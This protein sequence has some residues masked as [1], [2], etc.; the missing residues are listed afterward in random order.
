MSDIDG[1]VQ[2]FLAQK[3]VAVV[4]VSDRRETGCNAAYRRFK[5]AGYKTSAVNPRMAE[6]EG[7]PCYPDLASIPEAP[8]AVFILTN[9]KVS[10][11]ILRQC[12][13]LG[14]ENVWMHC[15]MGTKPGLASGT[16]SVSQ[17]AVQLARENG[18]NVIPGSCPNQFL[19]PDFGHSLMRMLWRT[20]GFM[21]TSENGSAKA[22][23]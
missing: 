14:I 10:E 18:I 16:T 13:D 15:M 17:A 11:Q 23:A 21:R 22:A 20:L 12:V 8:E 6:F 9:P 1:L 19:S 2:G 7:D 3:R 4:G 5:Q